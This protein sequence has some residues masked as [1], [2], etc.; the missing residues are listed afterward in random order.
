MRSVKDVPFYPN[1]ADDMQCMV[2][3]YRSI[4][5]YVKGERMTQRAVADYVGFKP[6]RAVWTLAPLTKM[7]QD[8][9][10]IVMIEPFDYRAYAKQGRSYLDTIFTP[11]KLDYQFTYTNIAEIRPLIPDFLR[12]VNWEK[13]SARLQDIDNLLTKDYIVFVTLNSR[14]LNGREGFVSHAVLVIGREGS[15]YIVHDPGLPPRPSRVIPRYKLWEAMGGK[16]HTEEVTG[17]KL[18]T[19]IGLRLDQYVVGTKPRLSR[20]FAAKLIDDGRVLVNGA[21]TKVGYKVKEDDKI[22]IDYDE[23]ILD[24]VP[25]ID[26]P[27]LYEDA[28]CI[29]INKPAGVLTHVQG[30]FNPEATVASYLRKRS[31]GLAG[32]RAGVVH[33]LDRATS[34][35]IIGAKNQHALKFLQAQ[36]AERKAKKTYTAIVE[37]HLKQ[38][39]AVIDMPIERNPKA[40][41]TFRVGVN[42]KAA[43]THY[44]VLKENDAYS[45]V[46]LKPETGRTHQLRVHLQ[47]VGH[48]IVGDPLYGSGKHGDRLYLHAHK[49]ELT[50]PDG[51]RKTFTAPLPPEFKELFA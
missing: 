41:A 30:E 17:F 13:R 23:A 24:T 2:S 3:V 45:L 40:P 46:E 38:P 28:D 34:G 12:S 27:V 19:L 31:E 16:D 1:T 39:E 25:D 9:F 20:A 49:L 8:G 14:E 6:G 42:G 36:F 21:S 7:A 5:E 22:T 18:K 44:K 43:R 47:R 10:D 11:E 37:G 26:L 51:E 15:D 4:I 32:D 48:P 29:V 33:R 35:V 50:L